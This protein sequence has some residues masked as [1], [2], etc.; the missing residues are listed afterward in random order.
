[1]KLAIILAVGFSLFSGMKVDCVSYTVALS[2]FL[3]TVMDTLCVFCRNWRSTCCL[4]RRKLG[5]HG[6]ELAK[7]AT[8]VVQRKV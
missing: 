2:L 1:M 5:S 8:S 4:Q 7:L 6:M 3:L